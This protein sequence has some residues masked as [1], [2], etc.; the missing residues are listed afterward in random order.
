M[1]LAFMGGWTA[2]FLTMLGTG[3]VE[4]P[5]I[6]ATIG[7]WEKAAEENRPHAVENL[8]RL[9]K[10][11]TRR[12]VDDTAVAVLSMGNRSLSRE[13][14][15]GGLCNQVGSIYAAGKFVPTDPVKATHY[16]EKACKLGNPQGCANLAIEYFR[17]NL[18]EAQI[19]IDRVLATLEQSDPGSTNGHICFIFGYAYEIGR[20]RPLDK[21]R[22][23]QFYEK[24]AALGEL[25]AWKNLARMQFAGEGGPPDHAAAAHWLQMAADAQDGPSCL[26]L[27]RMYHTGDGVSQDEKTAVSLLQKACSLGMEPA[28]LLLQQSH[29]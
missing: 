25:S 5:H 3:F 2:L 10:E 20:G 28:C 26:F 23:R 24:S 8:R 6:G 1:N 13:Q 4:A 14:A 12:D 29:P 18:T 27:A 7:F 15:L 16:F 17:T 21:A 19:D 9:L 22:A 11:F